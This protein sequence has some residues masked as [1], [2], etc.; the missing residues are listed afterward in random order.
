MRRKPAFRA[1]EQATPA[2]SIT[3]TTYGELS[4]DTGDEFD[5]VAGVHRSR[6][7]PAAQAAFTDSFSEE[8]ALPLGLMFDPLWNPLTTKKAAVSSYALDLGRTMMLN[9]GLL[10]R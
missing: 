6:S 5:N 8:P 1:H 10:G 9:A 7:P 3:S 4:N 2:R